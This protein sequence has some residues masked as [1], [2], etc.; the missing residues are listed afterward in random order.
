MAK[1]SEILGE[2]YSQVPENIRSQY[3]NVDLVD[4]SKYVESSEYEAL[5]NANEQYKKDIKKRDTDLADLQKKAAGN[6]ELVAELERVKAEN[7]KAAQEHEAQL[8]QIKFDAVL[9]SKLSTYKPKNLGLLK[10]AL[11]IEKISLD[12]ENLLGLDDQISKLKES[13]GYLFEDAIQG[14][15]GTLGGGTSR[16]KD[17]TSQLSLGARLAEQR[18]NAN[19]AAEL[20]NKFFN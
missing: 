3:E 5:K 1:L 15:T 13:D 16:I 14:G 9:E 10:K 6:E 19:Q 7:A 8:H 2:H 12:G 17:T 20:Q 11:E 4:S 18:K